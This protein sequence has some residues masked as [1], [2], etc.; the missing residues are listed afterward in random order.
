MTHTVEIPA[1]AYRRGAICSGC[2]HFRMD[3][4][5]EGGGCSRLTNGGPKFLRRIAESACPEGHWPV[6]STNEVRS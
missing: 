6:E 1:Y 4:M 5:R 3:L 2:P